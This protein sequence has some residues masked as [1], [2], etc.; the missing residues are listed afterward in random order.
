V[1]VAHQVIAG[2]CVWCIRLRQAST[3]I[4]AERVDSDGALMAAM[5]QLHARV[6]ASSPGGGARAQGT[7]GLERPSRYT[8]HRGGASM[9]AVRQT[10]TLA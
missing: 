2:G 1:A 4:P 5:S 6:D 9:T 8:A 3:A 7:A 10:E